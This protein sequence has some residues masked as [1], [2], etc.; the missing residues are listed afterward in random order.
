[1]VTLHVLIMI[2]ITNASLFGK[3]R[4]DRINILYFQSARLT[5]QPHLGRLQK[6]ARLT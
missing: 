3:I 4:N 1:M 5:A 2:W 6:S